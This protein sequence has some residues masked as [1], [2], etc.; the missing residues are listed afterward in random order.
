MESARSWAR[1]WLL[2]GARLTGRPGP[3]RC[4]MPIDC[5]GALSLNWHP[6]R[7]WYEWGRELEARRAAPWNGPTEETGRSGAANGGDALHSESGLELRAPC[8]RRPSRPDRQGVRRRS[9]P[10]A[11]EGQDR[12]GPK[13]PTASS[14]TRPGDFA[15]GDHRYDDIVDIGLARRPAQHVGAG[16]EADKLPGEGLASTQQNWT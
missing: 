12:P 4:E 2:S 5:N 6:S 3:A 8:A 1:S 14:P 16:G 10:H 7:Q 11:Q 9:D 13:P 15:A